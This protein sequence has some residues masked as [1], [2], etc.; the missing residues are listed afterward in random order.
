MPIYAA[1]VLQGREPDGRGPSGARLQDVDLSTCDLTGA[2]WRHAR[3]NRTRLTP[4][5]GGVIG[6]E[7]RGNHARRATRLRGAAN[8]IS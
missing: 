3:L 4:Q 2:R 7:S 1:R 5:L 6:E 8:A